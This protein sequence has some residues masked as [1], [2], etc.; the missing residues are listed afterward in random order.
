MEVTI[1]V[2][3]GFGV[4]GFAAAD[5]LNHLGASVLALDES[6]EGGRGR[7]RPISELEALLESGERPTPDGRPW[8]ELSKAER[9]AVIDDGKP[10][11]PLNLGSL[12]TTAAAIALLDTQYPWLRGAEKRFWNRS[13][14]AASARQGH[15]VA[16]RTR[17]VSKC[18]ARASGRSS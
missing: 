4:S 14:H 7:A 18:C 5:N 2:V 15:A 10:K 6:A 16:H 11:G 13:P 3:A 8:S 12:E 1:A 9:R 17:S